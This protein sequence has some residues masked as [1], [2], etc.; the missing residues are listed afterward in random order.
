MYN[1]NVEKVTSDLIQSIKDW[2]DENGKDSKAVIGISG[3]K[4][5]TVVAALCVKAL[6]KDRVL[7]VLLPNGRQSDI[8]DAYE[9]CKF[10]DIPHK[11]INIKSSFYAQLEILRENGIKVTQSVFENLP[12]MI[13]TDMI[14]S[15][16][17][18]RKSVV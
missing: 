9:V 7:G 1:F 2:F 4:D 12:P 17:R 14:R 5:S 3:G 18:D 6:G 11:C 8:E 10:L 16:C 15:I 13:R